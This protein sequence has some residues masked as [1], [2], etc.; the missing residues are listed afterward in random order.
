MRAT[1]KLKLASFQTTPIVHLLNIAFVLVGI[2]NTLLG[3]IL[4]LLSARWS[5]D[6]AG[7]GAL[8]FVQ[9][10]GAI[11]GSGLSGILIRRLG[12]LTLLPAS[13]SLM[14]VST[15]GVALESWVLGMLSISATGLSLGLTI[16]TVNLLVS[17]LNIGRRAAALNVLNLFWGLGAVS[18][19][20]IVPTLSRGVNLTVALSSVAAPLIIIAF[21]LGR[22][23]LLPAPTVER[24]SEAVSG[25]LRLW[26]TPYALLTAALVFVNI[27]T[28]S[29]MGGWIASYVKRLGPSSVFVWALAPSLFWAGLLSGRAAAPF[30][31]GRVRE[32]RLVLFGIFVAFT[33]MVV[34]ISGLTIWQVLIGVAIT[35]L[36]FAP[37]FPTTIALFTERFGVDAARLTGTL[38][39]LAGLGAAAFPWFVGLTSSYYGALR[40]GLVVPLIGGLIMI[41]LHLGIMATLR[42]GR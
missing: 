29:A 31:L 11:L 36:G 9:S 10:A 25:A 5:L 22:R 14:A 33:G 1:D 40:A 6:D 34:I 32:I 15:V 42:S 18:G 26:M 3:P 13:L 19:P 35:G 24:G 17:E 7:A 39:I 38:F 2:V 23:T 8:F 12:Y 41:L 37:V 16:P 27:G 4:P 21:L 30:I 28:E 20:L